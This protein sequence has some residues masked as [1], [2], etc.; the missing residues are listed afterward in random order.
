VQDCSQ[1][2]APEIELPTK[3][4]LADNFLFASEMVG[5]RNIEKHWLPRG[6]Q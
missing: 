1:N 5:P 4:S 2:V 6:T 3:V